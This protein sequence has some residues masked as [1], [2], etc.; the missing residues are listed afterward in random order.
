MRVFLVQY[1]LMQEELIQIKN[2]AISLTLNS[3]SRDEIEK[4]YIEFLGKKG[5]LTIALKE[6]PKL[7]IEERSEIGK[8]ANSIKDTLEELINDRRHELKV[9]PKTS[10]QAGHTK[11]HI[12]SSKQKTIDVTLP[13]IKPPLGSLH[14]VTQAVEEITSIFEKIGFT[15]VRYPEVEYDFYAFGALNFPENHPARDDW[16]TFF[17]D[18]PEDS[19]KGPILLTPHTSSGQVRELEKGKAS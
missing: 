10:N 16:E 2:D 7:K 3:D 19:K 1:L 14:L 9:K 12:A 6:I 5:R 11:T 17:V 8:L 18:L 15:R 13:G 4:I